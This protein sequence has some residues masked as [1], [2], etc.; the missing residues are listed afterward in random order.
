MLE[1][2]KQEGTLRVPPPKKPDRTE[3]VSAV[4]LPS[5]TVESRVE[6]AAVPVLPGAS[7]LPC[8][9]RLSRLGWFGSSYSSTSSSSSSAH[10]SSMS[11]RRTLTNCSKI[12]SPLFQWKINHDNITI[13]ILI[14]FF[15]LHGKHSLIREAIYATGDQRCHRGPALPAGNILPLKSSTCCR[16][17][18]IGKQSCHQSMLSTVC[19]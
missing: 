6:L 11:S 10:G 13:D 14:P 2:R 1:R 12:G 18:A 7:H 9:L 5:D 15:C 16:D 8:P 3:S 4:I 19:R 17:P